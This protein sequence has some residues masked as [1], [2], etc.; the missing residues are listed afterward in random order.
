MGCRSN[1]YCLRW[2][3]WVCLGDWP[4]HWWVLGERNVDNWRAEGGRYDRVYYVPLPCLFSFSK[5]SGLCHYSPGFTLPVSVCICF[6]SPLL[7]QHLDRVTQ[8]S[9]FGSSVFPR[10]P[11]HSQSYSYVSMSPP[12]CSVSCL[13]SCTCLCSPPPPPGP[14]STPQTCVKIH[15]STCLPTAATHSFIGAS[16]SYHK[17]ENPSWSILPLVSQCQSIPTLTDSNV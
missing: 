4:T 16:T 15:V 3:K 7:L 5:H 1:S 2:H 6:L 13:H 9:I 12:Q 14:L 10:W 17:P 11:S 8:V